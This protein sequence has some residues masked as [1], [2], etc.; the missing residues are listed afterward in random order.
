[1]TAAEVAFL[2]Q[3]RR[4]RGLRFAGAASAS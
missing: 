3:A 2:L 4:A 1:M